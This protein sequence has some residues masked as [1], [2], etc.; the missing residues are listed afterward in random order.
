MSCLLYLLFSSALLSRR[1]YLSLE[2]PAS[3]KRLN[4]LRSWFW[5]GDYHTVQL[6]LE[7]CICPR[8]GI[9]SQKWG[10]LLEYVYNSLCDGELV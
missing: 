8:K 5:H 3:F 7:A 1:H 9:P 6:L 2:V 4:R 10:V